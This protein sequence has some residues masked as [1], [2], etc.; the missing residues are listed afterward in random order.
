MS[1]RVLKGHVNNDISQE[2]PRAI[3]SAMFIE[4]KLRARLKVFKTGNVVND[5]VQSHPNACSGKG[6]YGVE[7]NMSMNKFHVGV[8]D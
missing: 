6:A 3:K 4:K 8:E 2:R 1:S 5:V 7:D